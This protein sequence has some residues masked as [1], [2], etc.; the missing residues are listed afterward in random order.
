MY[1]HILADEGYFHRADKYNIDRYSLGR[2]IKEFRNGEYD[3]DILCAECENQILCK[4]YED[5]AAKVYQLIDSDSESFDN[6]KINH[7]TNVN[8]FTGIEVKNID[9]TRFKL[10][11]LSILWRASIAKRDFFKNVSLDYKH[12]EIIRLMLLDNN[13][14][15]T[16][17]YPCFI[18]DLSND[19]PML[20]GII[21]RPRK[22]KEK[23]NTSYYFLIAGMMY[24]F[25]ISK[26]NRKA[27][28]KEGVINQDNEMIIWESPEGFGKVNAEIIKRD[29]DSLSI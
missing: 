26:Y 9:Y 4:R 17:D 18:R 5:Y 14:K 7:Y 20:K 1:K 25:S 27:I 22:L 23:S 10:F 29:F 15:E 19:A 24:M 12:E 21:G 8:G 13:P 28:A 16:V 11:L 2:N 6:I 3:S